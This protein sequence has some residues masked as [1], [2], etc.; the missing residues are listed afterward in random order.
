MIL[1]KLHLHFSALEKFKYFPFYDFK[2]K[3]INYLA[4]F[5][6]FLDIFLS[7]STVLLEDNKKVVPNEMRPCLYFPIN[8][9]RSD[10]N[11]PIRGNKV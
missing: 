3:K 11:G 7:H 6:E 8:R 2:I 5:Q 1:L 4:W 9:P 10:L